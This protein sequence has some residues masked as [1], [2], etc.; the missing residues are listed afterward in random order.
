MF[1]SD[2]KMGVRNEN[3]LAN[4]RHCNLDDADC[5]CAVRFPWPYR[6][7]LCSTA[8]RNHECDPV[9]THE[10]VVF[11]KRPQLGSCCIRAPTANRQSWRGCF[12][13]FRH[14]I[15]EYCQADGADQIGL[16]CNCR[17]RQTTV[18][19][20][21]GRLNG[22]LQCLS[23]I[24]GTGVHYNPGAAGEPTIRQSIIFARKQVTTQ[25]LKPIGSPKALWDE[26]TQ[27]NIEPAQGEIVNL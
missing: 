9:T 2:Q 14:S 5:D 21:H 22:R 27:L 24:D 25:S 13:L 15:C 4:L 20:S 1:F 23:P 6:R 16:G 19:Q 7:K 11:G 17:K 12:A 26:L 18:F 10:A 3:A 8:Q